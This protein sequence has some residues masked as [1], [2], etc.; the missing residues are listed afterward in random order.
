[1]EN[2]QLKQETSQTL[3]NRYLIIYPQSEVYRN[4]EMQKCKK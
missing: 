1:M 3:L 2:H 4:K